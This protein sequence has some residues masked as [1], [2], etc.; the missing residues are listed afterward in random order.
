[1]EQLKPT[2]LKPWLKLWGENLPKEQEAETTIY[3]FIYKRN[4][5]GMD[6]TALL[7]FDCP[8]TYRQVFEEINKSALAF[9][10]LGVKK[11]D[12]V[13]ICS[14]MTPET[15]YAFYAL[16]LLGAV[17]NMV[18]PRTSAE[19]F[20]EYI[21]EV[22]SKVVCT[23]DLVYDK[24]I[25]G[26]KGTNVTAL[27]TMSPADSIRGIKKVLYNLTHK[28]PGKGVK[29][30][31][32]WDQFIANGKSVK[33]ITPV[34]YDPTHACVICHTGGTTG[35]PKGVLLSDKNLNALALQMAVNRFAPDQLG[36]NIM[37]PFIAYGYGNGV[38]LPFYASSVIVLIPNFDPKDFGKLLKKYKPH[39][40]AGVPQ[41]YQGLANDKSLDG[42]D[43]SF[44]VSTGCGGDGISTG[45]EE[46]VNKFFKEHNAKYPLC[47]GYGMTEVSSAISA[48]VGNIN[49]LGS[50]GIPLHLTTVG[51][52]KEGTDEELGFNE[53]GEICV[54]GP[55][56][57]LGYYNLPEET[58]KVKLRHRDGQEWVHTGDVGYLD[59]EG[60][61]FIKSRIKRVIIRHDGFKVFPTAIENVI[62]RDRDVKSSCAVGIRDTA[63]D[64]GLL[65]KAY[66]EVKDNCTKTR[67]EVLAEVKKLCHK[68][69]AEYVVP[70]EYEVIEKMPYTPIGKIDYRKLEEMA[71]QNA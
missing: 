52:F 70:V 2:N 16:D 44:L 63:H 4:E 45:A 23:L 29:G 64:Q 21:N 32:T 49:K 59:E 15:I 33:K 51:I 42:V 25:E 56:V 11:G 26:I 20:R 66:I 34:P 71:Q 58:A 3:D 27:V 10:A 50:V 30:V 48:C 5:H 39:H 65:P 69:L 28:K 14:V 12:I 38:H 6:K 17:A 43:L 7:Y 18:D 53:L 60:Y 40:T 8:I 31:M 36:L 67:E 46:A 35:F 37:P 54:T 1:M 24:M 47:K 55:N 62:S 57:M 19:G 9:S 13:T 22:D 61:L 41:H 68:D